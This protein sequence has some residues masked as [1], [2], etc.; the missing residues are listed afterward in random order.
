MSYYYYILY[1]CGF[2]RLKQILAKVSN[3]WEKICIFAPLFANYNG[4]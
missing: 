3:K 4:F 1:V 2:R